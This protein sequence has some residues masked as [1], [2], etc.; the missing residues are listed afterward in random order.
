MKSE[1]KITEL[2]FSGLERKTEDLADD[3]TMLQIHDLFSKYLNPYVPKREGVLTGE[4]LRV[5][6]ECVEFEGPYAHYMYEGVVYGPNIPII[7]YGEAVGYFSP[8]DKRKRPTGKAINYQ[9]SKERHPLATHH[10]DRAMM[11]DK[12]EAFKANVEKILL[13]KLKGDGNG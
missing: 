6:S 9:R 2:D 4:K 11:E 8:K 7:E 12:G 10:W 3:K 5:T 13:R 1:V